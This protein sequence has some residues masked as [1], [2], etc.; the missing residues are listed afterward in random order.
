MLSKILKNVFLFTLLLL[1]YFSIFLFLWIKSKFIEV[2]FNLL[3]FNL[4]ILGM[5]LSD[6]HSE[7]YDIQHI[8]F[9]LFKFL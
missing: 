6:D 1:I 3:L 2:D 9:W 7:S 4:K 5:Y 8:K